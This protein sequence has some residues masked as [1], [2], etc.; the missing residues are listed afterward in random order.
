MLEQWLVVIT[1]P[2][3]PQERHPE[4][5]EIAT[6][7]VASDE[8][9]S[10]LQAQTVVQQDMPAALVQLIQTEFQLELPPGL[11]QPPPGALAPL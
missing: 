5:F 4:V 6:L 8:V 1:V 10:R 9:N 7:L 11:H 2:L 3:G